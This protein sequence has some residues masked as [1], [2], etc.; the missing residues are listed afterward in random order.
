LVYVGNAHRALDR[1]ERREEKVELDSWTPLFEAGR[2]GSID[3]WPRAG[4]KRAPPPPTFD[5]LA[6]RVFFESWEGEV[7]AKDLKQSRQILKGLHR[8]LLK[9]R[10][11]EAAIAEAVRAFNAIDHFIFTIEREDICDALWLY[12]R[13]AG[14]ADPQ[15]LVDEHR[16]W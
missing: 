10:G 15:A 7:E 13:A 6:D 11:P 2:Y 1:I 14:L 4:A 9:G 12:G 8:A 16:D 3:E 5:E